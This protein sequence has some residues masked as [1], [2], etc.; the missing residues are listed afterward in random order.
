MT[1]D[2]ALLFKARLPEAD[3]EVPGLGVVRVRGLSRSEVLSI[4]KI[5]G[6]GTLVIERKMLA[7]AMVSPRLTESEVR[8]WQ[9]AAPAGEL[10]PV[11]DKIQELSGMTEDSAKVAYKEFDADPAAEFRLL[12]GTETE[13]DGGA[14]APDDE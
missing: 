13:H 9:E 5:A 7:L 11:T 12:P 10:E 1:V 14:N 6:S 2:K 8:E 3:V 4:Q